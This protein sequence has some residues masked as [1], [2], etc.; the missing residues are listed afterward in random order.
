[1]RREEPPE[2]Q[3]PFQEAVS[4]TP[5]LGE[6][7]YHHGL[8]AIARRY[9]GKIIAHRSQLLGSV[10]LDNTLKDDYP[11]Q[12]RWDYGIGVQRD[13]KVAAVWVEFHPAETNK[14]DEVLR[15]LNWLRVWLRQHAPQL[16]QITPE[17]RAFHWVATNGCNVQKSSPQARR[18][19]QEGLELPRKVLDLDQ[20]DL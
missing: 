14:V 15:K 8:Q 20:L 10:D 12:P 19:F 16:N 6:R 2:I 11:D 1:M 3:N 13:A 9:S 18:L 7:A 4:Q 17:V 5:Q